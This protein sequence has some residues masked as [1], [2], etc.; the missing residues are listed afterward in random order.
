MYLRLELDCRRLNW[1]L[2]GSVIT[3][4]S[5]VT[6]TLLLPL[7]VLRGPPLTWKRVFSEG[8]YGVHGTQ[9]IDECV[10]RS[11]PRVGWRLRHEPANGTFG[12]TS[13]AGEPRCL[14][15]RP[16][17]QPRSTEILEQPLKCNLHDSKH[18]SEGLE[19]AASV[20][21]SRDRRSVPE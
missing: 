19:E 16:R 11:G 17:P 15:K 3:W 8:P 20:H 7:Q 9:F 1:R 6:I 12:A 10:D 4:H 13:F 18:Q 21:K 14:A 2:T 5:H